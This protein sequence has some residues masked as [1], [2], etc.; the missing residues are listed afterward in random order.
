VR[1]QALPCAGKPPQAAGDVGRP[2]A[3]TAHR[4]LQVQALLLKRLRR[5]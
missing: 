5:T 3:H 1:P 2:G 4:R